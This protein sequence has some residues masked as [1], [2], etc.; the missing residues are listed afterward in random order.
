MW[1]WRL[2]RTFFRPSQVDEDLD[3][4]VQGYLELLVD[5]KLARGVSVKE[6]RRMANVEL[7][8]E[9]QVKQAVRDGRAGANVEMVW[10]DVRY[11]WR[12]LMRSKGF[13]LVAVLSLGLG[14]GANTAIFTF[15]KKALYDTL[16]VREPQSLRMLTWVSGH[17]QVVP[18][19]WGDVSEMESGG[20]RSTSFSYPVL[21]ALRRQRDAFDELI[22]FTD[23]GITATVDGIAELDTA[24]L[25]SGNAFDALGVGAQVGRVLQPSDDTG[26]GSAPVVVISDGYWA[27]RF[28]RSPAVVGKVIALNGVPVTIVGVSAKRFAGLQMGVAT[29]IFVP[30]TMQPQV[31]PRAQ[32]GTTSLLENPRSWWVQVLART[33]NGIPDAR[34]EAE[35]DAVMRQT[36]MPVLDATKDI[37]GFHLKMEP[38][39]RGLDY[40]HAYFKKPSYVLM[41]LA[42]LV[43]VLACVNLANL[44][45]ARAAARQREMSTRLALGA[46]RMRILRQVLTESLLLSGM[47]GARSDSIRECDGAP[48]GVRL[49]SDG[50]YG[51]CGGGDGPAVWGGS[52][53]AGDADGCEHFAEGWRN[54]WRARS[55]CRQRSGGGADCAVYDSA[56]GRGAF[57]ADAGEPG[58]YGAGV[59]RG[60]FA[61]VPAESAKDDGSG[62][63]AAVAVSAIGRKA[64]GDSGSAVGDDVGHCAGWRWRLGRDVSCDRD[65]AGEECETHS[66]ERGEPRVL[67]DDGNRNYARAEI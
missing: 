16:P 37:S 18:P 67:Q 49:A 61:A 64:G 23:A 66:N 25:V 31:V 53:M 10:Q 22:A 26:P 29:E 28:G 39:A 3:A 65:A 63:A 44:L 55:V 48:G 15:A 8:G 41:A 19:V 4:E 9:T 5:E 24:E 14:I 58:A 1:L 2:I 32:R 40:L 60:S 57:C 56:D 20:L 54:N 50:V 11:G 21:E 36:A 27:R 34:A 47:G 12:M 59:S 7:G 6:A 33:R 35:L 30:I 42:G 51:G 13:A 52:G 17:E 43:L 46:G 62:S 38:G 45:L